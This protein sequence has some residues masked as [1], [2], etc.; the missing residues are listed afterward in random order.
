M[1]LLYPDI[2]KVR[3]GRTILNFELA[4]DRPGEVCNNR[5]DHLAWTVVALC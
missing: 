5:K 4:D 3:L 2:L 1:W